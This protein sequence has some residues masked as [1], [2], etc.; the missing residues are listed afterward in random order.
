MPFKMAGVLVMV[1]LLRIL[2]PFRFQHFTGVGQAR[3]VLPS[4]FFGLNSLRASC[5][6]TCLRKLSGQL[7]SS[8]SGMSEAK[9]TGRHAASGRLAHQICS[10]EMWPCRI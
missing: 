2:D 7:G 10:V 8:G 3:A 9:T 5:S 1:G 6:I 4:T